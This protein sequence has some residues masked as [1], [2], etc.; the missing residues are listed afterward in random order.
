[1]MV[2][3]PAMKH[4]AA[5]TIVEIHCRDCRKSIF[6][7]MILNSAWQKKYYILMR[8]TKI[9]QVTEQITAIDI[10]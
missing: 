2:F 7:E 3:T 1:M 5:I 8:T 4:I 6:D 10:V 9:T